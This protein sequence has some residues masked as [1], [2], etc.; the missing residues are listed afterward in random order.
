LK[1][2]PELSHTQGL[3]DISKSIM[4]AKGIATDTIRAGDHDIAGGAWPDMTM[5]G[6]DVDEL[7]AV[8]AKVMA[9]DILVL[10]SA[11]WFGRGEVGLYQGDRAAVRHLGSAQ[12]SILAVSDY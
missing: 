12:R 6:W 5:H 4:E 7:P 8:L 1:K 10:G 11:I 9:A 2:S 3:I